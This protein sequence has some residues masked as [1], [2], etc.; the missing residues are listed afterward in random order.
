MM[1]TR[2]V[3]TLLFD[4]L[5]KSCGD[6]VLNDFQD[7]TGLTFNGIARATVCSSSREKNFDIDKQH[8]RESSQ[9][10][11]FY[12]DDYGDF[13]TEKITTY[14]KNEEDEEANVA[15][16]NI[17]GFGHR[18][19]TKVDS[20]DN[21]CTARLRITPSLPSSAGSVWSNEPLPVV[22]S[23]MPLVLSMLRC[24]NNYKQHFSFHKSAKRICHKIFFSNYGAIEGVH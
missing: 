5:Y 9:I 12:K 7:I 1:Q 8:P 16:S 3:A 4:F 21:N 23:T 17:A 10:I 2:F 11:S 15:L 14:T 19:M 20:F 13:V 24:D 22:C 18:E 6:F